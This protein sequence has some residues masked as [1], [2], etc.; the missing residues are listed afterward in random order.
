MKKV[1]F[2]TFLIL[3]FLA[4]KAQNPDRVITTHNDTIP[5]II[6]QSALTAVFKYRTTAKGKTIKIT[7]DKIKEFY[8]GDKAYW[9][10]RVFRKNDGP[11]F[12]SIIERGKICLYEAV[13]YP[14]GDDLPTPTKQLYAAKG[15]DTAILVKTVG[16][17][18][19]SN[20]NKRVKEF[21]GL[22]S[23]DQTAYSQYLADVNFSADEIKKLVQLYDGKN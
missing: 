7:P 1:L 22:L 23:D 18:V 11:M 20:R 2:S 15:S 8:T 4:A 5:C 17:I 9:Y 10:R 13:V 14:V 16:E 12:M 3:V 19:F 6:S 21:G